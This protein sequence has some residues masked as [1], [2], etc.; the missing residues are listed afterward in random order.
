MH[1]HLGL[2]S[3]RDSS[4]ALADLMPSNWKPMNGENRMRFK[5]FENDRYNID[6]KVGLWAT[7][8]A[9]YMYNAV[10]ILHKAFKSEFSK[11]VAYSG[12]ETYSFWK[13]LTDI[14]SGSPA[15]ATDKKARTTPTESLAR[16]ETKKTQKGVLYYEVDDSN[17]EQAD[18]QK[19]KVKWPK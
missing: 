8:P 5:I 13:N 11:K 9:H 19:L 17:D 10:R 2:M 1:P 4:D 7:N 15:L 6:G 3:K 14:P 12:H 16:M 18:V